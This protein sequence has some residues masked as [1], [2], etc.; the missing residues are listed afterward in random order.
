MD[1]FAKN[2]THVVYDPNLSCYWSFYFPAESQTFSEQFTESVD[3]MKR[4]YSIYESFAEPT[5]ATLESRGYEDDRLVSDRD[6]DRN[7]QSWIDET[8]LRVRSSTSL[9]WTDIQTQFSSIPSINEGITTLRRAGLTGRFE[10]NLHSERYIGRDSDRYVTWSEGERYDTDPQHDPVT[11]KLQF[12]R[13]EGLEPYHIMVE[14]HTDLWFESTQLG[15]TN[16]ERL[17]TFLHRIDK[18]FQISEIRHESNWEY[19]MMGLE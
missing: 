18:E 10:V 3:I 14:T 12:N 17:Q 8:D 16:R 6:Q 13:I 7:L 9:E 1:N 15:R 4:L 5:Q 2:E 11:V 19:D